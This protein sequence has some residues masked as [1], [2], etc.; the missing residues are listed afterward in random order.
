M[1]YKPNVDDLRESPAVYIAQQLSERGAIVTAFE[2]NNPAAKF[3]SF[4]TTPSLETAV[5]NVDSLVCLVAHNTFRDL[6]PENLSGI[7]PARCI[8][9]AVG[10]L[11]HQN[12]SKNGFTLV[13]L[14]V[15]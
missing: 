9:D 13:Q 1:A 7:T 4:Q 15:G 2:P 11:P 12:W 8:F 6:N 10:L 3:S 14:G 5:A